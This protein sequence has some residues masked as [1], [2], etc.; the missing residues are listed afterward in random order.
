MEPL[1]GI[2]IFALFIGETK[3]LRCRAPCPH[4]KKPKNTQIWALPLLRVD[5]SWI[6]WR[7]NLRE[8]GLPRKLADAIINP[9]LN[10]SP[11]SSAIYARSNFCAGSGPRR[12]W[13]E[14]EISR[15]EPFVTQRRSLEPPAA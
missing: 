3:H 1:K 6:P 2:L 15:Y 10:S 9:G 13:R 11:F 8:K 12:T 4:N 5:S 7:Q 14:V